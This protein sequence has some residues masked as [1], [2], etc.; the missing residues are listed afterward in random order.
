MQPSSKQTFLAAD[1]TLKSTFAPSRCCPRRTCWH[2]GP[3]RAHTGLH[4]RYWNAEANSRL[5]GA[6]SVE[7]GHCLQPSTG[8][9]NVGELFQKT[10]PSSAPTARPWSQIPKLIPKIP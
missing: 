10:F 3:D 8:S 2:A 1:A 7:A 5:M 6:P 9:A 4:T